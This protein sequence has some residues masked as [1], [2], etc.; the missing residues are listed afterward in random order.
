MSMYKFSK[1][2]MIGGAGILFAASPALAFDTGIAAPGGDV[3]SPL[4]IEVASEQAMLSGSEKFIGSMAQRGIDFLGDDKLTQE[5]RTAKFRELLNESFDIK[6]IARFSLGRYWRTATKSQKDEY[7]SLFKDM[8]IDVYSG[9][10]SEY[11]GQQLRVVSSR[12]DGTSDSIVTTTLISNNGDPDVNI[13]WRV[14]YKDGQYKVIDVIVE[15][16][17]MALTQRSDFASVIQRG[18]GEVG[19]LIAHLKE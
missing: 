19:V 15:G 14:R 8:I 16:V 18:G 4:K 5:R 6:T 9:R 2:L 12:P 13:D 7:L 3:S 1:F 11:K 17:S 10:F